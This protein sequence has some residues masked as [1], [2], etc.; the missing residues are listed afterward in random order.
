MN[1]YRILSLRD[2]LC[3]GE[4]FSILSDLWRCFDDC[5]LGLFLWSFLRQV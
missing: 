4:V 5:L 1:I 2:Q 3:G